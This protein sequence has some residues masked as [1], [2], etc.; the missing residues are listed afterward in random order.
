MVGHRDNGKDTLP[1]RVLGW[2]GLCLR[3][4]EHPG[5]S[6]LLPEF[7]QKVPVLPFDVRRSAPRIRE[8]QGDKIIPDRRAEKGLAMSKLTTSLEQPSFSLIHRYPSFGRLLFVPFVGALLSSFLHLVSL[9]VCDFLLVILSLLSLSS[10]VSSESLTRSIKHLFASTISI[11]ESSIEQ[12]S[13]SKLSRTSIE[14][15]VTTP[16]L[17]N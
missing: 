10:E 11:S 16:I 17:T 9:L 4:G 13:S 7:H 6:W 14:S 3:T 1:C 8:N 12:S 5:I 15:T 2:E